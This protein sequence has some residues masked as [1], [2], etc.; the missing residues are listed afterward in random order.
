MR[1]IWARLDVGDDGHWSQVSPELAA[2]YMRCSKS[3]KDYVAVHQFKAL[4]WINPKKSRGIN[5][6]RNGIN[7]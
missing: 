4:D 5:A 1:L 3:V 7:R 2:E 6:Y